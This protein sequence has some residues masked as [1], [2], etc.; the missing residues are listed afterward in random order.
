MALGSSSGRGQRTPPGDETPQA[1][2]SSCAYVRGSR[3]LDD[4][5][6]ATPVT[7]DS[8]R[9]PI[10]GFVHTDPPSPIRWRYI[11]DEEAVERWA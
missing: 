8:P 1:V 7:M 10:H 5:S 9:G 4:G 3:W 2:R 11:T 6:V